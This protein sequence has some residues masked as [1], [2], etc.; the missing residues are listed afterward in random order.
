MDCVDEVDKA[1]G[2]EVRLVGGRGRREKQRISECKGE[3][4]R[5]RNAGKL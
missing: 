1:D 3:V 4:V 2:V 5:R